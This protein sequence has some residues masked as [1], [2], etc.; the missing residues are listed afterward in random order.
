MGQINGI[1]INI[2]G[3]GEKKVMQKNKGSRIVQRGWVG[4]PK[5]LNG[6]R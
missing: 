4:G 3:H 2:L 6:S 1:V 5:A